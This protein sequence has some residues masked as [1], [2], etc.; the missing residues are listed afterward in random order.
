[1]DESTVA[2]VTRL[3]GKARECDFGGNFD[4]R[5]LGHLIQ[6]IENGYLIKK[7]ISRAWTL[8]EFLS[9]AGK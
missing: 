1:M 2:Y 4:E 8:Q 5:I 7:C 3:R 9:E 6:T